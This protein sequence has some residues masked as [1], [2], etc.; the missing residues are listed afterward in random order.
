MLQFAESKNKL[1]LMHHVSLF[2]MLAILQMCQAKR[3]TAEA[4]MLTSTW[5]E[6]FLSFLLTQTDCFLTTASC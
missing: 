6:S 1:K 5:S 3:S 2:L 4:R